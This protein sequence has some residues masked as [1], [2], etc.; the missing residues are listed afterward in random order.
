MSRRHL[1]SNDFIF[2]GNI[3]RVKCSNFL[4]TFDRLQQ[5]S[6]LCDQ[7]AQHSRVSG[8]VDTLSLHDLAHTHVGVFLKKIKKKKIAIF[9][10]IKLTW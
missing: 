4:V 9:I 2:Y 8:V 5:A 7:V 3:D 6:N 1:E 10:F